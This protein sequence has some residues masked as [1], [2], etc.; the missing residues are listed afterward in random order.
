MRQLHAYLMALAQDLMMA[1]EHLD[2]TPESPSFV[3]STRA[4]WH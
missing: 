2:V 4:F 1:Q 3:P